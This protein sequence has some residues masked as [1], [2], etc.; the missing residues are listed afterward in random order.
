VAAVLKDLQGGEKTGLPPVVRLMQFVAD[1]EV[2]HG[3]PFF[4]SC[5]MTSQRKD[6]REAAAVRPTSG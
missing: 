3:F 5:V 4:C 2:R 1:A 6:T